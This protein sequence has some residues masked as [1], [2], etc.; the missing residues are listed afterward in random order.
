[1]NVHFPIRRKPEPSLPRPRA[2]NCQIAN[3]MPPHPCFQREAD[4]RTKVSYPS[5]SPSDLHF[6]SGL[7]VS[8]RTDI[9]TGEDNLH[10]LPTSLLNMPCNPLHKGSLPLTNSPIGAPKPPALPVLDHS[11]NMHSTITGWDIDNAASGLNA[12]GMEALTTQVRI[13]CPISN[14]TMMLTI[15]QRLHILINRDLLPI[16]AKAGAQQGIDYFLREMI[17]HYFDTPNPLNRGVA[18]DISNEY[19]NFITLPEMLDRLGNEQK[20]LA[21]RLGKEWNYGDIAKKPVPS[22]WR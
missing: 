12:E 22:S 4:V 3:R 14:M 16:T 17:I 19:D 8:R 20:K 13:I 9:E 10:H 15:S 18:V 11:T 1:M 2:R 6:N 7:L 5:F 21:G